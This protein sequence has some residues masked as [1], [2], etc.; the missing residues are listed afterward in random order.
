MGRRNNKF[1]S[2]IIQA[3]FFRNVHL[4]INLRRMLT[5][6]YEYFTLWKYFF[7]NCF[8]W[9]FFI[10]SSPCELAIYYHFP[11]T[12]EETE[13]QRKPLICPRSQ[14]VSGS[15]ASQILVV[16]NLTTGQ[17]CHWHLGNWLWFTWTRKEALRA[18]WRGGDILQG[19]SP[20]SLTLRRS[21]G[22]PAQSFGAESLIPSLPVGDDK[23]QRGLGKEQILKIS[24]LENT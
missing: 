22:R 12:E 4:I 7:G 11:L 1:F 6:I 17:S 15:T 21:R 16:G 3:F 5:N 10:S 23:Q 8:S 14:L 2:L 9:L 24:T 13:T 19:P 18:E 20:W